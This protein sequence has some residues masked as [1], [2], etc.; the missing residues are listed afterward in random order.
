M[1]ERFSLKDELFNRDTVGDLA[2]MLQT[3]L[4]DFDRAAFLAAV[5]DAF[6]RL[7]LKERIHHIAHVLD[8]VLP[9]G[10]PEAAAAIL[11][12]LPP[13]LDPDRTDGDFGRFIFA[14]FGEH[15][16]RH[17]IDGHFAL[18]LETLCEL[19]QRF[20]MEYAI[21]P[22]LKRYPDETLAVLEKW[23]SHP[24][25]HVRRLVSE[26]TRPRLPWGM[27]VGL[28]PE[29]TIALLDRLHADPTRYVTRSVANHLNDISKVAPELALA[30][31]ARWRG[32]GRQGAGELDWIAAHALRT[33]VKAGN[34][35]ALALV[36]FGTGAHLRA[37]LTV[38][39]PVV[40]IGGMLDFI[41]D[42]AADHPTPVI[43][44]YVIGFARPDGKARRKVF[45]LGKGEAGPKAP[46][47]L[48]K[49]LRLKGDATTFT[50]HPGPH[51]L[52][53][54]A[55]GAAVASAMFEVVA[56]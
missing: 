50:L 34:A 44:D 10:F 28:P 30:T 36:G 23:T 52:S 16:A 43:V 56:S 41:V 42:I 31:V 54:Q 18:A 21:R 47:R 17:G 13:P 11:R 3:A 27:A 49:R 7:E 15:V 22:F 38:S 45:R 19:T 25:Y 40:P 20:S 51:R 26:G 39:T 9:R 32:E 14:P 55:N 24:N 46:L 35:E 4:Q 53:V 29:R 8:D 1:A 12:A 2:D 37:A 48:S 5:L 6:P 33:L